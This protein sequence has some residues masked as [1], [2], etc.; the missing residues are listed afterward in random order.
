MM[1]KNAPQSHAIM[2]KASLWMRAEEL[3]KIEEVKGLCLLKS[4]SPGDFRHNYS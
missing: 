3:Q 1:Q 2:V 4:S